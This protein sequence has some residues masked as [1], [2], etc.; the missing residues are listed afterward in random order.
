MSTQ[1]SRAGLD[2]A[3]QT[4]ALNEAKA[5]RAK[6]QRV[7]C[8]PFARNASGVDIRGNAETWWSKA[9]GLYDRGAE[10]EVGAVMAFKST[11]SMPMGHVAV[12]SQVI[13]PREVLVD[14]ANWHRNEVSL[15]MPVIDVSERNDWS[16]VRLAS[17]PSSFGSVYPV[18]GFIYPKHNG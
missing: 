7:W 18:N 15:K 9:T 2:P 3:R 13:S 5:L 1:S 11:G 14:H 16:A 6:G 10:P 4:L 8:V 17:E 12:V